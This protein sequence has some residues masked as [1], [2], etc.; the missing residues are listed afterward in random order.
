MYSPLGID[1]NLTEIPPGMLELLRYLG[2]L[3]AG[4]LGYHGWKWYK[5]AGLGAIIVVATNFLLTMVLDPLGGFLLFLFSGPI[6]IVSLP[7]AFIF[8]AIAAG[9]GCWLKSKI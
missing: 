2:Y 9:I 6:I 7:I 8:C 1:L 5:A 4:Y 3:I